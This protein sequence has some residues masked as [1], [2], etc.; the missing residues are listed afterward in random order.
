MIRYTLDDI[1]KFMNELH[2]SESLEYETN[3]NTK[4]IEQIKQSVNDLCET[5]G[6][7]DI[8]VLFVPHKI[9]E[10]TINLECDIYCEHEK[11]G[12]TVYG[13][14]QFVL[15]TQD[16]MTDIYYGFW[17]YVIDDTNVKELYIT[18]NDTVVNN[19]LSGNNIKYILPRYFCCNGVDYNFLKQFN[20][21]D[22]IKLQ[23]AMSS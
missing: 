3:A 20:F 12:H 9:S 8:Y 15:K 17:R 6:L 4:H 23:S 21:V 19:W 1:E 18:D 11:Y 10:P 16:E 14:R 7:I 5:Y 13:G 2:I 22:M